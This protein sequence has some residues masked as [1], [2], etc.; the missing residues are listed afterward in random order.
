MYITYQLYVSANAAVAIIRFDTIYQ[1]SYID[2]ILFSFLTCRALS[3]KFLKSWCVLLPLQ[4]ERAQ[5]EVIIFYVQGTGFKACRVGNCWRKSRHSSF[6]AINCSTSRYRT[7]TTNAVHNNVT[8]HMMFVLSLWTLYIIVT[9]FSMCTSGWGM[10]RYLYHTTLTP[11]HTISPSHTHPWLHVG[12]CPSQ[13]VSLLGPTPTLSPSYRLAQTIFKPN[14]FPYKYPNILNP[15]HSWYLSAYEDGTESV[16]NRRRI[17]FRRRGITQKKA[18]SI[19]NR[20]KVWNQERKENMFKMTIG[21]NSFHKN[22]NDKWN[23]W[24]VICTPWFKGAYHLYLKGSHIV[25]YST[26]P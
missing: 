20:A 24:L 3:Y 14:L 9:L 11:T 5:L 22:S 15:S 17:K 8:V 25:S 16:L 21:N 23:C 1:R 18:Y 4:W 10:G 13:P 6:Y 2:K 7:F 26:T 12:H 19:Q